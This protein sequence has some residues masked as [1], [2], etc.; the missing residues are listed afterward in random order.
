MS[1]YLLEEESK[2]R[3]KYGNDFRGTYLE[4]EL[5]T[6]LHLRPQAPSNELLKNAPFTSILLVIQSI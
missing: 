1:K 5:I 2:P 4:M 3:K 6:Y